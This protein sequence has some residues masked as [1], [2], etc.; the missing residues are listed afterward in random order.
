[1]PTTIYTDDDAS[2]EAIKP[3]PIAIIGYGSQGR[4]HARNLRDSGHEVIVGARPG[5]D[6]EAKAQTDGFKTHPPA[7][8][9]RQ[10]RLIA[11]LTPD[12][13]HRS[14]YE[15]DIAPN[16]A[17]GETLMVEIGRAHV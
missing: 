10:A 9:A 11:L 16:M 7:E 17:P 13:T 5:G 6:A 2:P 8:A 15:S 3:G 4:A 1:M 12:M 14:V